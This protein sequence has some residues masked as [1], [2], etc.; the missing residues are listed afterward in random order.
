MG[1]KIDAARIEFDWICTD[2]FF[3][4]IYKLLVETKLFKKI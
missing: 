1:M 3:I 2:I 4:K